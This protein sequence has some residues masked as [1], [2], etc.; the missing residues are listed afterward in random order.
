[1]KLLIYSG[2]AL[3]LLLA[4]AWVFARQLAEA[5]DENFTGWGPDRGKYG[6]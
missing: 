1:M 2:L 3:L 6:W 5:W 4:L